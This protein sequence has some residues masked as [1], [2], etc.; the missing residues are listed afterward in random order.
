MKLGFD[1]HTN[2]VVA[3]KILKKE[4]LS[5]STSSKQQLVR[6]ITAMTKLQ[7]PNVIKLI[8]YNPNATYSNGSNS[9]E[10]ETNNILLVLELATGGELFEF[11]AF[12]GC[13]EEAIA[14]TYFHDLMNAVE[15]AHNM[16]FA[17]RDLKPEN[18]LLD[19]NFNLKV[20][21]FGFSNA[22]TTSSGA[23][24][25]TEC[26]TLS[27]M[28]PEILRNQGYDARASDVWSCGIILFIMLAG[29]PP[30]Q[31]PNRGDWW[32]HKLSVNRHAL[33][34]QAHCRNAYFSEATKDF[35]NKI[36][37]VEP[38]RRITIENMKKHPW[39]NGPTISRAGLVAEFSRRKL[40]VDA[41]KEEERLQAESDDMKNSQ[42]DGV[43][44]R[45]IGTDGDQGDE[46]ELP[47]C[48]PSMELFFKGKQG[49]MNGNSL[50]LDDRLSFDAGFDDEAPLPPAPMHDD[51]LTCFTKFRATQSPGE[52]VSRLSALF[53]SM[54][55]DYALDE[56]KY[57]FRAKCVT[58]E[59]FVQMTTEVF[60]VDEEDKAMVEFRRRGG[61]G[62]QFRKLYQEIRDQLSDIVDRS[63]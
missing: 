60:R 59:G 43:L 45:A 2:Q 34:W 23:L 57:K 12:T 14:R 33:F 6:E 50:D 8:E 37:Q 1:P 31:K 36:L 41:Q 53:K 24:M 9:N 44:N 58:S 51:I 27:Y 46:D 18:L 55:A 35:I 15:F 7:H 39:W 13:F 19:K 26:G 10:K 20:A 21:D 49:G 63:E 17:H 4:K 5:M 16:G 52:V 42:L 30:I 48:P 29:F 61:D 3:L 62:A 11:L 47:P 28:A 25:F 54:S 40:A 32:F 22:F 38:S 56:P